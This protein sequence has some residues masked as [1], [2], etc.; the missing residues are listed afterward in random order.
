MVRSF[1]GKHVFLEVA[2]HLLAETLMRP[3][4]E[5][6]GLPDNCDPVVAADVLVEVWRGGL[7]AKRDRENA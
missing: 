4:K 7:F 1:L 2:E 5:S 3:K 6:A